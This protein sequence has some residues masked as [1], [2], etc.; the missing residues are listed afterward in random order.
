MVVRAFS[1]TSPIDLHLLAADCRLAALSREDV[2]T[3]L[4]LGSG[5][6]GKEEEGEVVISTSDGARL[7][8]PGSIAVRSLPPFPSRGF[9][10]LPPPPFRTCETAVTRV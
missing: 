3:R 4:A 9:F 6:W 10:C 5:R 8:V 2:V 1:H 7:R